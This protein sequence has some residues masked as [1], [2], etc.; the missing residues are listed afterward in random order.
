[1]QPV[2]SGERRVLVCELW[3]GLPRRCVRRCRVPW[4]PCEC[5]F[6]PEPPRYISRHA[7]GTATALKPTLKLMARSSDEL[8]ALMDELQDDPSRADERQMVGAHAQW[9]RRQ[10]LDKELKAVLGA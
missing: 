8:A 3:E 6:A 5:A 9:L 4:G 1:M 2:T 7:E 10:A